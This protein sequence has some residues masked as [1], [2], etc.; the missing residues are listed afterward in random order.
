[1]RVHLFFILFFPSVAFSQW[2]YKSR[3]TQGY[4][5]EFGGLSR[6]ASFN[7]SRVLYEQPKGFLAS[8]AGVAYIWGYA[9]VPGEPNPG[10]YQNSG[11]GIPL[12]LTYNY[13]IGNI[14]ER[15]RSRMSRKCITK[16]SRYYLDWF[17]EG[18]GG[19]VPSFFNKGSNEKNR[20]VYFGTLGLRAQ[21]KISR[22]YRENDL[23]MFVRGGLSPFYDKK[24]FH[25]SQLGS[26][27]GSFG[28]G[29]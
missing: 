17:A 8:S 3:Y 19:I 24:T 26:V 12:S 6:G 27:Y 2:N 22:P 23:V 18:G 4:Y 25:F 9:T 29:I 11:L 15:L 21:L 1:V 28:F 5:A 13:S 10:G 20:V 14:E 16:P 7:Y